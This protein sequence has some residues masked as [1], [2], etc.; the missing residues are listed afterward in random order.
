MELYCG[1]G[2]FSIALAETFPEL[3]CCG[4]EINRC[5]IEFARHNAVV[6]GV[7]KRCKFMSGDALHLVKRWH[8][9]PEVTVL[10]D[11][12][13]SG[14][15]RE[16]LQG[17]VNINAGTL[18]YISCA[19]DTLVRDLKILVNAGYSIVYA[20]MLDMFPRTGHFE[21]LVVLKKD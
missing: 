15:S 16:A 11:P 9:H 2:V 5:A 6:H 4:I 19:A 14:I 7:E 13:R 12:P 17:I 21:S 8:N 18:I 3:H 20:R 10:T 1:T